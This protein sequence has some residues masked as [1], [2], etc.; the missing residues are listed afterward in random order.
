VVLKVAVPVASSVPVPKV[1]VPSLNVTL[2]VAIAPVDEV[3]IAVKVTAWPAVD[4]LGA[5]ARLVD[6]VA[7]LMVCEIAVEVLVRNWESPAYCAVIEAVPALRVLVL[8]IALPP[9]SVAIPILVE[10][11]LN[12]TVSPSGGAPEGEAT[13]AVKTTVW[14]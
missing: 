14:P 10:P 6:V 9:E 8:N 3:T 13:V 11:R 2:P 1:V 5:D 4:G 12:V 7:L